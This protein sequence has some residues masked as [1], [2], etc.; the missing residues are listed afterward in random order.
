[1]IAA[2]LYANHS[3]SFQATLESTGICV[4]TISREG[5]LR[6]KGKNAGNVRAIP[7]KHVVWVG[8]PRRWVKQLGSQLKFKN[9]HVGGQRGNWT[10]LTSAEKP[11]ILID[12]IQKKEARAQELLLKAREKALEESIEQ[13]RKAAL[14]AAPNWY[15]P[16]ELR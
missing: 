2:V 11:L 14:K 4:Y 13:A 7:A 9:H 16:Q 8:V 12:R 6:R 5:V 15:I 3:A 10:R 1:M